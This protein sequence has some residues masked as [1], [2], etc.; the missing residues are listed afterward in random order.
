MPEKPR[1]YITDFIDDDLSVERRILDGL[2]DVRS[3][4]AER[5]SQLEGRIED[6]ACIMMYHVLSLRAPAIARLT[7]CKLIVRCGVGIDNVDW[8][9]ARARGI[10]VCNV[11]DYGTEDVADTAI[12][13]LLALTRGI[14]LLNS[15][16][17]AARGPWSHTQAAPLRR[18]RDRVFAVVGMGRIG[19]AASRRAQ[20]LG[21]D[22]VFYDPYVA[23][24]WERAHAVRRAETLAE[25]LDE[26]LVLSLHCPATPETVGMI[27]AEQIAR[28]PRGSLLIN[29]ARGSILDTSAV[30][31]AIRSGQLA[32][33]GIDV[34]PVEPPRDDDPL[35]AAWRD[36]DDPCHDRVIVTPHAAFYCEEGLM[37]IRVKA[38]HACRKALLGLPLRNVVN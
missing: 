2:A 29:T 28:L 10:P 3:L 35:I 1:V 11:P 14:H 21:M 16:L 5:E 25:L 18:L 4:G 23:D 37:D 38:A 26:A 17:R 19:T 12:A 36:P 30:P 8:A 15:R 20:A 33:A 22:V 27:G 9:A 24:G 34:L 13:M 6:A 32:G 7:Q 31:P